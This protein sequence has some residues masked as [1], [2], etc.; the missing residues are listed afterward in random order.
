MTMSSRFTVLFIITRLLAWAKI[1]KKIATT[2]AGF[3][4]F[5]GVSDVWF[6]NPV[7]YASNTY[8]MVS[9]VIAL[10]LNVQNNIKK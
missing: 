8:T 9:L 10:A 7:G 3:T 1:M 2:I 5:L 4:L 6:I